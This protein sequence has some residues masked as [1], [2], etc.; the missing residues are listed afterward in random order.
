MLELQHNIV[1]LL[2]SIK[3]MIE[4]HLV[5]VE[6]G[7]IEKGE[8]GLRRAEEVLRKA[9]SQAD[10]ALGITKRLGFALRAE[11]RTLTELCQV[12]V[13]EAWGHTL[14][15]LGK[16]GVLDGAEIVNRLRDDFPAIRCDPNE[17]KEVLYHLS[18]N[19]LQA[20]K[21]GGKLVI[22]GQ[23]GLSSEEEPQAVIGLSDTGPGIPPER[24]TC[25]FR[26][27]YTTQPDGRGNGLG[28]YISREL[29]A[30][31]HGKIMASSFP[32]LGTTF[33]LEFPLAQKNGDFLSSVH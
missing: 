24:L 17:F 32:G 22:R 16:E 30:K 7:R 9:C 23:L 4:S 5:Q 13:K 6:E 20:M 14:E 2:Y 19:A 33:L 31:N 12:S 3:G 18:K 21:A 8:E 29:V 11:K 15:L 28:L 10:R 1:S 26:P 27:F 25:L